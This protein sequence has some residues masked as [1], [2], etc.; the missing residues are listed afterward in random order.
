M[1]PDAFD[2]PPK[3]RAISGKAW[4][5]LA[6]LRG[7]IATLARG[8]E[9][10]GTTSL[11]AELTRADLV[12]G[13][14]ADALLRARQAAELAEQYS[15]P[16]AKPL[17]V[18]SATLLSAG[19][20]RAAL[21]AS[22][23]AIERA[24]ATERAR[25]EVLA[26]LLGGT[27]QRRLGRLEEA[28]LLLGAARGGA[29]RLGEGMLAGLAL[30]ETAWV[31][32][33]EGRPAAAATCLQFAAE[34][35]R[36]AN[37][38]GSAAEAQAL[39]VTSWAAAGDLDGASALA[40]RA[41]DDARASGR[42]ELIA[43]LDG[44][45]ADVALAK[46]S[47]AAAQ[48]CA[49]AAETAHALPDSPLARELRAS[50]RLRQVRASDDALDR[51]RHLEAG[52]DLALGLPPARAGVRLVVAMVGLLDDAAAQDAAPNRTE[53]VA[54]ATVLKRLGDSELTAMADSVLA[55]LG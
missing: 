48:A 2:A 24:D 20:P 40:P 16:A 15:A 11:L 31:D 42:P 53:V 28:R 52:I 50:A 27:A 21:E 13:L 38:P 17:I 4:V 1:G 12:L 5:R 55:E 10:D 3:L 30:V 8:G 51:E 6:Q 49:L 22:A 37:N 7:R 32:H 47:E 45:L 26:R 36:R 34:F 9:L 25:V 35:F 23:L 46:R 44:A 29:A 43:F 54:L 41:V 33:A 39:A 19:E 18:L 14:P